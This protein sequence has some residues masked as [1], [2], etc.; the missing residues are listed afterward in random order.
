MAAGAVIAVLLSIACPRTVVAADHYALLVTGASGGQQ[1]AQKYATWRTSFVTT[2]REKFGYPDDHLIVL[3]EEGTGARRATRENV[4]AALAD[5]RRRATK[6]DVVLLLLIGHGSALDADQAKFNLVGPDLRAD[7]WAALV[8]PITARVV[9]VDAAAGSFPFLR[10]L[11]GPGRV[12]L[13]AN[14]SAAQ[15]FETVFPEFLL[16]AFD[17]EAA[18]TDKSGK[19]S[20][21]EAFG[22]A[23]AAVK[24]WFEERG[25]LATERALL[26]DTG[27][28]VGR[29]ADT[30]GADG[31]LARTT[32]FAPDAPAAVAAD[33]EVGRLLKRRAELQSD[34][35]LLR[36]RKP[37]MPAEQYEAELEKLLTELAR[38][39]RQ[40]RS[41]S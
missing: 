29:E 5:F 1:F 8:K 4:R 6:D 14:D 16:K 17:D 33:A 38:I 18:D 11:A 28:G 40:I 36:A 22:Y 39:D 21:W 3:S 7:E 13:T 32:Y 41:K 15:Q 25:L 24:T 9:F 2:F 30:N 26:D 10:A 20:V 31:A 23:S 35:D 34:V 27:S 37:A 19:V 12:I